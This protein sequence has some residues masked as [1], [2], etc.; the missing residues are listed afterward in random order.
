[1]IVLPV[2]LAKKDTF[3][4]KL[5]SGPAQFDGATTSQSRWRTRRLSA[6]SDALSARNRLNTCLELV[7]KGREILDCKRLFI[8]RRV[9]DAGNAED[10]MLS[11]SGL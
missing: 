6:A 5:E 9:T 10:T 11:N 7:V 1:M 4:H 8:V 2:V 3:L